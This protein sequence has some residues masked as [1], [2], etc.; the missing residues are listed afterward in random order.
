M[1]V[2]EIRNNF[3]LLFKS[4]A[5]GDMC[6]IEHRCIIRSSGFGLMYLSQTFFIKSCLKKLLY[7]NSQLSN[8]STLA[9]FLVS[10]YSFGLMEAYFWIKLV[11][12]LGRLSSHNSL[13]ESMSR[14]GPKVGLGTLDF[15]EA[16]DDRILN[17]VVDSKYLN[18]KFK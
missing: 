5:L 12:N 6:P 7:H 1:I 8:K 9:S 14:K 4:R 13:K 10:A 16:L 2:C 15:V 11:N 17:C 18:L 3:S